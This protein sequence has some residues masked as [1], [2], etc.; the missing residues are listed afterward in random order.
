MIVKFNYL[1][2]ALMQQTN[3]TM[4]L[5]SWTLFDAA[6]GK[7]ESYIPG[8]KFQVLYLYHGG[9]GDDSDYVYFSNIV[10]YAEE[11]KI[12]VVMPAGYNSSYINQPD[13]V[14]PWPARYWDYIFEEL[15]RVCTSMFPVSAKREDTFVGGL[16]MGSMAATK[17]AVY[18]GGR[19]AA[20]L[21]MSGGGMDTTNIM[22][23]VAKSAGDGGGTDFAVDADKMKAH[24]IKFADPEDDLFVTAKKNAVEGKPLPKIFM[25]C[26]ANDFI[27]VF[28]TASR[29]L[30]MEYGYDVQYE[31]APG[32]A[33]E[34]D[35]WDL[36]LKTALD[37]WLP[38][39][40]DVI[41]PE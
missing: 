17:W 9:T 18:G 28:A 37:K 31:E 7:A 35:F 39:R 14:L 40:H 22:S 26:G 15:P 1:S 21:V 16:S 34:W 38:I 13:N 4:I 25:T 20:V 36:S 2:Q 24:G 27:R 30:L 32:Y 33:H 29:D 19:C 10:R 11:H 8:T 23:V 41:L 3:V 5:P 6:K 12:A